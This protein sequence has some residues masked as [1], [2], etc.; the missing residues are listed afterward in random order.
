[1]RIL[2]S[3]RIAAEGLELLQ[4]DFEVDARY[5]LAE[6]ELVRIIPAYD[7]LVVRSETKVTLAVIQAAHNLKVIGRAGVG[8]DNIDVAAATERG[9]LVLNAPDGNT[10]A[11][12]EHTL[13]LMLALARHIPQAH[14]LVKS[15]KWERQFTGVELYGKTLGVIGLGRIG[16]AVAA[17]AQAFGMNVLGYDPGRVSGAGG[18]DPKLAE[19]DEIFRTADFLTVHVPLTAET[20]HLLN[21]QAFERMK[22]GVR[23]INC[24]RGG[25][26]D[27][28]ALV[29]ALH[30]GQVGGAALDV[31][32]EE[33]LDP[34]HPLLEFDNVIVTP[35]LGASTREAQVRV[36]VTVA[37]GLTAVL[38]GE[39]VATA[40]NGS[41]VMVK[42]GAAR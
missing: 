37:R 9:I 23:I 26:I 11:A 3:D 29:E 36:A 41:A 16:S 19:L 1:M 24:A 12:A 13:G 20:K 35:H 22:P 4:R 42:R 28:R 25:I 8:V 21:Q 32:E 5:N 17:R 27:E 15:G 18:A 31:F 40:V 10:L 7:G 34:G 39:T 6:S 30:Q 33:P 2:V 14:G 38:H